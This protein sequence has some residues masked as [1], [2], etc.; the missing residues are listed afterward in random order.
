MKGYFRARC[1]PGEAVSKLGMGDAGCM[2]MLL[3]SL[4]LS[5]EPFRVCGEV[6]DGF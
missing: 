1:K 3:M 4:R 6:E 5:V 2:G